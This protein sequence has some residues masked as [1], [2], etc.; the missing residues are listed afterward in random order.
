ML[1]GRQRRRRRPSG[2]AAPTAKRHTRLTHSSRDQCAAH[3]LPHLGYPARCA[4]VWAYSM[5]VCWCA[6]ARERKDRASEL[7]SASRLAPLSPSLSPS[8]SHAA[9]HRV[10]SVCSHVVFPGRPCSKRASKQVAWRGAARR[11]AARRGSRVAWRGVAWRGVLVCDLALRRRCD[12]A[13]VRARPFALCT[14]LY[15][16]SVCICV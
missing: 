8:L 13:C 4:C 5:R 9:C 2:A 7:R 1:C 15:H 6:A 12:G 3:R 14:R 16:A 10:P 11:I